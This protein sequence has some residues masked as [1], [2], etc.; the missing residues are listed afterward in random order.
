MSRVLMLNENTLLSQSG[1][2]KM[3]R[4]CAFT[5][6][7]MSLDWPEAFTY[8]VVFGWDSDPADSDNPDDG[9]SEFVERFGWDE[10]L[11]EFLR[12]A[13]RRFAELT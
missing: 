4:R 13:H 9:W 8:A 2:G 7:D 1:A 6:R 11:I 3:E 12:D 10:P 5:S